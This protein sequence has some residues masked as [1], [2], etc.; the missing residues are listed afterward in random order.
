[1]E[2]AASIG[3]PKNK[4]AR[5]VLVFGIVLY[6]LAPGHGFLNLLDANT[7][8]SHLLTSVSRKPIIAP[9]DFPPD[10]SQTQSSYT[11]SSGPASRPAMAL[12]AATAGLTR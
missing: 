2:R 6:N 4:T 12:A 7:P 8:V 1:M 10:F 3:E 9:G 5:P 11:T